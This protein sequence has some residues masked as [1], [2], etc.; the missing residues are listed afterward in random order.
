MATSFSFQASVKQNSFPAFL[1]TVQH[2]NSCSVYNIIII[3]SIWVNIRI[4]KVAYL[5]RKVYTGGSKWRVIPYRRVLA[6]FMAEYVDIFNNIRNYYVETITLNL[7]LKFLFCWYHGPSE[8][9][10]YLLDREGNH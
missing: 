4:R 2:Y 9:V 6:M 3:I 5:F 7:A 8:I 1:F 10:Y